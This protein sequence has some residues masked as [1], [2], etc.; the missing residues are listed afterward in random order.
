MAALIYSIEKSAGKL[1]FTPFTG[2]NLPGVAD[3]QSVTELREQ[4]LEPGNRP[5]GLDPH[6]HRNREIT[7]ERLGLA[8]P[9]VQPPIEKQ[10]S[11]GFLSMAIC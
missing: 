3:P 5:G 6:A 7:V 4:P 9:V 1:L 11:S 10:L 8:A 2:A